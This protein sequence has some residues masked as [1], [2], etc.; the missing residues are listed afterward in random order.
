MLQRPTAWSSVVISRRPM[1]LIYRDE[2]PHVID[3][4]DDKSKQASN[5]DKLQSLTMRSEASTI[6]RKSVQESTEAYLMNKDLESSA[7][8]M[9]SSKGVLQS[10]AWVNGA[11]TSKGRAEEEPPVQEPG[12]G[13]SIERVVAAACLRIQQKLKDAKT[14]FRASNPLDGYMCK[15]DLRC[16][17]V[18]CNLMQDNAVAHH[19]AGQELATVNGHAV[20][21]ATSLRAHVTATR[22][23]WDHERK[24]MN[25]CPGPKSNF[26]EPEQTYA[27]VHCADQYSLQ[28]LDLLWAHLDTAG[29]GKVDFA[30]FAQC[31]FGPRV[32]VKTNNAKAL[33][34]GVVLCG[35]DSR[36][37]HT[38]RGR[39]FTPKGVL[40]GNEAV[41]AWE[42]GF[43][44]HNLLNPHFPR[45]R[46]LPYQSAF[47][48]DLPTATLQTP[49][50]PALSSLPRGNWQPLGDADTVLS[51]RETTEE[52]APGWQQGWRQGFHRG[53]PAR[54]LAAELTAARKEGVGAMTAAAHMQD[55]N[56]V[57]QEVQE[58]RAAART[59]QDPL[60]LT[61]DL[62]AGGRDEGGGDRRAAVAVVT[63]RPDSHSVKFGGTVWRALPRSLALS[64]PRPLTSIVTVAGRKDV[65]AA[66]AEARLCQ[67]D[68]RIH[69]LALQDQRLREGESLSRGLAAKHSKT[70]IP[71]YSTCYLS[72]GQSGGVDTLPVRYWQKRSLLA[73]KTGPEPPSI[74][75]P[76]NDCTPRV[77]G[78]IDQS[79]R[80]PR[81]EHVVA[82]APFKPL[83]Q[84]EAV[85]NWTVTADSCV[86]GDPVAAMRHRHGSHRRPN[87]QLGAPARFDLPARGNETDAIRLAS[88]NPAHSTSLVDTPRGLVVG[89]R[90]PKGLLTVRNGI[91]GVVPLNCSA[92]R[93]PTFSGAA[94]P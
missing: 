28:I 67:I 2:I 86:S 36:P 49:H 78:D 54:S 57:G 29:K 32:A 73:R 21:P 11:E 9:Q 66:A 47:F 24:K 84:P 80:S 69:A 56:A 18:K 23:Q 13:M 37:L 77:D 79:R 85:A 41:E 75:P 20:I 15:E 87:W 4:S 44:A 5:A 16:L 68:D 91:K 70:M 43:R 25:V 60:A 6:L 89:H 88:N 10:L 14:A 19:P 33:P 7:Q 83:Q 65:A 58:V 46:H 63:S 31:F 42:S 50:P 76:Y 74:Q 64:Q 45:R 22:A 90:S 1:E 38:S 26:S 72:P 92:P 30:T 27:E 3:W 35:G 61:L 81:M 52:T 55:V 40:S 94:S 48:E 93:L 82:A 8:D 71:P 39:P 17:L 34:S 59:P 53:T 12:Q 51:G 62:S